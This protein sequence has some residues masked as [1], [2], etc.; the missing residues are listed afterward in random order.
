MNKE[1]LSKIKHGKVYKR[2]KQGRVTQ[3]KYRDAVWAWGMGLEKPK[4]TW[5]W[6]RLE[7][8]R[9][10][11]R[12]SMDTSAAKGTSAKTGP[13]LN[14]AGHLV[15]KDM[16]KAEVLNASFTAAC[17]SKIN[18]QELQASGTRGKVWS[19]EDLPSGIT[20]SGYGTFKQTGHRQSNGTCKHR[21]TTLT[22]SH[23]MLNLFFFST[24]KWHDSDTM[25]AFCH[26]NE[27]TMGTYLNIYF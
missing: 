4:P 12:A 27:S 6:I 7:T 19:K 10:R 2:Q 9:L 15:T 18:F 25:F 3:E 1:L 24:Q 8:W 17:T 16:K 14:E 22:A 21:E 26:K 5:S 11:R 20:V 23:R 13:L